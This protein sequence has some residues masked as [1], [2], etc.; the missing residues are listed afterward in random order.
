MVFCKDIQ[1]CTLH[2]SEWLKSEHWQ[3]QML[4]RIWQVCWQ[5]CSSIAGG[6]TNVQSPHQTVSQFLTKLNTS[7]PYNPAI[8]VIYPTELKTNVH[9]KTCMSMFVEVLFIIA[10]KLGVTKMSFSRWMDKLWYIHTLGYFS[11]VKRNEPSS[12]GGTL[13]AYWQIKE[14]SV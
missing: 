14:A 4:T 12:H 6:N 5:V 1:D 11:A 13:N 3:Q 8:P 2:L 7:L 10:K 9:Q